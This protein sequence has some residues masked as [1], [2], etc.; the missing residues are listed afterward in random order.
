MLINPFERIPAGVFL[1]FHYGLAFIFLGAAIA[2]KDMR[3]SRLRLADSLTYLAVFGLGHGTHEWCALYLLLQGERLTRGEILMLRSG[4]FIVGIFSY[5]F[6]LL[7]GLTLLRQVLGGRGR[8]RL[9]L[10]VLIISLGWLLALSILWQKHQGLSLTL[11]DRADTLS[12]W[13]LAFSASL[14]SGL[15]LIG[16]SRTIIEI[17][18]VTAKNLAWAGAVFIIYGVLAGLVPSGTVVAL[19]GVRVELLRMVAA[20][21]ITWFMVKAL[22]IFDIETRQ[23]LI[24]QIRKLARAEKLASL[25][26]L[27]VGVAHEINNPLTNSSLNL[28]MARR[29]LIR[30]SNPDSALLERLD[31]VARNI[32]R[33]SA[34]ARQLLQFSRMEQMNMRSVNLNQVM[35]EGL[36]AAAFRTRAIRIHWNPGRIVPVQG[37]PDQL[38]QVVINLINNGLDAMTGMPEPRLYLQTKMAGKWVRLVVEDCG[39]GI[40]EEVREKIFDPFFTTREVGQGT[41]L[42]LSISYGIIRQHGGRIRVTTGKGKGTAMVIELPTAAGLGK[43]FLSGAD[44]EESSDS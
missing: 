15:A 23:A 40:S 17:S 9:H 4:E 3:G 39:P 8:A 7:F 44:S 11:L 18:R 25:G 19:I 26:Q 24:D 1:Y 13:I 32:D 31:A 43:S 42:G 34:I 27:A 30:Q 5:G 20:I 41:G 22:N 14:I 28:E 10:L 29:T 6:L 35:E 33:A 37:D 36:E 38:R 2:F 21:L 12:R 16:Y